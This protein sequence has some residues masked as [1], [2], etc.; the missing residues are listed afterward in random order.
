MTLTMPS[1]LHFAANE[2]RRNGMAG[3]FLRVS[4]QS[5]FIIYLKLEE[6]RRSF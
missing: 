5:W 4:S 2:A 6:T 1:G 3:V